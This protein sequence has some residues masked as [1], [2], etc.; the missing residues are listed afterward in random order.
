MEIIIENLKKD[1]LFNKN[2]IKILKDINMNFKSGQIVSVVGNSGS[3]K[4]TLLNILSLL[5]D[6][7][8]GTY[9]WNDINLFKLNKKDKQKILSCKIGVIFQQ[10]NLIENMSCFE[11][12]KMPLYLNATVSSKEKNNIANNL[13]ERVG[14]THRKAHFPKTLSGG[15]QQRVAIARALVNNPKVVFAD[16]PTGNVDSENEKEILQLFRQIA[17]EGKIVFIVTHS[18]K[19]K[20]VSDKI[21]T[22]VDGVIKN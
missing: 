13:I 14:L 22:I 9:F 8:Q 1:V 15:E 2:K 21:Y 12:I 16:E 5:D 19:V 6:A 7:T 11:N 3:G 17:N 10:Y 20:A 18:E 4:S